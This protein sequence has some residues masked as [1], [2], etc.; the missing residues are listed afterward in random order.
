[1]LLSLSKRNVV[2]SRNQSV[3]DDFMDELN[4]FNEWIGQIT[5]T[6]PLSNLGPNIDLQSISKDPTQLIVSLNKIIPDLIKRIDERKPGDQ[7]KFKEQILTAVTN[8]ILAANK[9]GRIFSSDLQRW[10]VGLLNAV[11]KGTPFK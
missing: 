5:K 1:M 4:A 6:Y 8:L 11:K 3:D 9:T 7:A 10:G 2:F